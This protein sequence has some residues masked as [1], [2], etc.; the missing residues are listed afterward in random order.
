MSYFKRGS[1][2]LGALEQVIYIC[3]TLG[4]VL[5]YYFS[6]IQ[7]KVS[8]TSKF[9]FGLALTLFVFFLIYRK[10]MKRKVDELRNSVT[11]TRTDLKNMPD[12]DTAH[13]AKLAENAYKDGIKLDM[14][15]RGGL[16]VVLLIVALGV[17]ILNQA[18]IGVTNLAYIACGSVL[19]G[20]GV[21]VGVLSLKKKE[22]LGAGKKERKR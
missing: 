19:T 9:S 14:Y 15:D 7:Q 13:I 1:T 5:Y 20:F 8:M 12:S 11:Q 16:V 2:W 17:H 21:H 6:Q 22:K 4:T 18:M 3:P 10:I